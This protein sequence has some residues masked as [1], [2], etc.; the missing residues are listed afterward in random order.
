MKQGQV[1]VERVFDAF[2]A[3]PCDLTDEIACLGV[4]VHYIN[5]HPG[6]FGAPVMDS[7]HGHLMD[8]VWQT[9]T[10]LEARDYESLEC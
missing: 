3:Y 6:V 2:C 4:L 1:T 5:Q 9:L 8:M 7:D 10:V